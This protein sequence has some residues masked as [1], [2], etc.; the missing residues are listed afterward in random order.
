MT[1]D[2]IVRWYNILEQKSLESSIRARERCRLTDKGR[3]ARTSF[4][5]CREAF[6]FGQSSL[7]LSLKNSGFDLAPARAKRSGIFPMTISIIARCSRLSCVWKRATPVKNS[8]RMQP[9]EY[10]SHGYD[11]PKPGAGVRPGQRSNDGA[12]PT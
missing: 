8:T 2:D 11:Q 3:V 9:S 12:R 5:L 1:I 7:T 4:L 6:A 10:A